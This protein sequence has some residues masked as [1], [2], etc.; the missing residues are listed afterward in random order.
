MST[1]MNDFI[2]FVNDMPERHLLVTTLEAFHKSRKE[3]R[4][5]AVDTIPFGKYKNRLVEDV[6]TENSGYLKW[7][8]NN[9]D[10]REKYPKLI[11]NI[12]TLLLSNE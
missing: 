8:A 12:D 6:F 1:Y 9:T 3:Q 4:E 7:M 5:T 10:I 2:E 11:L